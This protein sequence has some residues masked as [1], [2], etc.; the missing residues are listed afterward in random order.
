M[1]RRNLSDVLQN[2]F[3]CSVPWDSMAGEGSRRL[4][5]QCQCEV[6]DFAQME[7]RAVKARVEA[8]HGKLCARLT[9]ERGRLKML[10][11][12]ATERQE[13]R[14]PERAPALAA[15][16]FGG[17]LAVAA[18]AQAS[19][20]AE[21][22]A[23]RV[24]VTEPEQGANGAKPVEAGTDRGQV[25]PQVYSE[26]IQVTATA[27]VVEQ[28]IIGLLVYTPLTL[29]E[30]FEESELVVTAKV[31]TSEIVAVREGVA[32]VRT[33]LL[34]ARRFKG[35]GWDRVVTYRHSLP[36]EAFEPGVAEQVPELQPG[37]M[38]LAFLSHAEGEEDLSSHPTYEATSYS[39]GLRDLR[40]D[41]LLAYSG[42]L[43]DL[44]ALRRMAGPEGELDPAGLMEW[45]VATAENPLTRSEGTGGDIRS[46][47]SE[48]ESYAA[49]DERA[50]AA[51]SALGAAFTEEQKVRLIAA[52]LATATLRESDL[53]FYELVFELDPEA[54]RQWLVATLRAGE[55]PEDNYVIGRLRDFAL[56]LGEAKANAFLAEA[57]NRL[58]ELDA[59]LPDEATPAEEE[60]W[61]RQ[62]QEL[63]RALY[64]ELAALYDASPEAPP[65]Q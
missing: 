11:P 27:P 23:L 57:E 37:T 61:Q 8:S 24:Q 5:G 59:L 53:D 32:E 4:C 52:L 58:D 3:V 48:L 60:L 56:D 64:A 2:R 14:T 51:I 29:R 20:P 65:A 21:R 15:G 41:A 6:F 30:Q 39:G 36:V 63:T 46:A 50:S 9:R 31:G 10:A 54:A 12:A 18:S 35:T 19:P 16:I 43:E 7:P 1:A 42:L 38:V 28:S 25:A 62:R 17:L 47:L 13:H 55:I 34:V 26:E 44:A 40:A 33:R 22:P 49:G 45:L